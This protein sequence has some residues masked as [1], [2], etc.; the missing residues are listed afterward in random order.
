MEAE[1]ADM[2]RTLTETRAALDAAHR[3]RDADS[4]A[5]NEARRK[6]VEEVEARARQTLHDQL[7]QVGGLAHAH[8]RRTLSLRHS[9]AV[10]TRNTGSSS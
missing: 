8:T 5:A 9:C 10:D 4:T 7:Q 1:L 3:Q 6:E 2:S